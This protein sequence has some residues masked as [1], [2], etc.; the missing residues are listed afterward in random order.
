MN[1]R[2]LPQRC[3]ATWSARRHIR[4]PSIANLDAQLTST[5][6]LIEDELTRITTA[7]RSD[8]E[9]AQAHQE[10]L[11]RDL[12]RLRKTAGENDQASARLRALEREADASRAVYQA[13]LT[14]A[15]ET[16]EQQQIDKT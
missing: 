6:K 14:R 9:R 4:N 12:D 16:G 5:R 15:R 3:A 1:S 8:L 13:F 11:E 7:V 2:A 10:S